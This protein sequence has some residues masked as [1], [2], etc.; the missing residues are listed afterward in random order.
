M[1]KI[2]KD[3]SGYALPYL[4]VTFLLVTT[5]LVLTINFFYIYNKYEIRKQNKKKLDLACYSAVQQFIAKE[6][7]DLSEEQIFLVDSTEVLLNCRQKGFYYSLTAKS[8]N[9]TDSS[10][11][12]CLL[13]EKAEDPF[14]NAV[15]ISRPGLNAVVAGSTK[16]V[17]NIL[18]TT[19]KVTKGKI[20]G[21]GQVRENY[22]EGIVKASEKIFPKLF[23]DSVL[24]NEI[25]NAHDNITSAVKIF[26]ENVTID[27]Y[28][29]ARNDTASQLFINGDL[30]LTG[31]LTSNKK[32]KQIFVSGKT[33]VETKTVTDVDFEIYCDSTL[34]INAEAVIEN[35]LVSAKS[36]IKIGGNVLCKNVQFIS[37]KEIECENAVMNFP[38]ILCLYV[39]PEDTAKQRSAITINESRINGTIML[40]ASDAASN[41]NKSRILIDDKSKI[42]G[43]IYSENNVELSSSVTGTLY[44][45]NIMFYKKPT[46]YI[47][48]LVNLNINRK[49]LDELFLIPVG[50]TKSPKLE[51]LKETWEY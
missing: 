14:D 45:Y 12:T 7:I 28:F 48:W 35:L 20:F 22:H 41:K 18:G 31:S 46:Q 11:V 38:S 10:A 29:L 13:A 1:P 43:L 24:T 6:K 32:T 36:K 9:K 27:K 2:V 47:N 16:I 3:E 19:D 26:D 21:V 25:F 8:K 42:Q 30:T 23:N 33:T 34:T 44:T 17:G 15:V 39:E 4:L 40:L 37:Q 50:F 5:L 49:K 51:I